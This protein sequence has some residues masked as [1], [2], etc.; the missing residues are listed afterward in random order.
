[1]IIG[2]KS[3]EQIPTDFLR[4]LYNRSLIYSLNCF[5]IG[6]GQSGK[7]TGVFYIANRLKQIKLG[8]PL[9]TAT[10]KEWDYKRFTSTDPKTFVTLWDE[11]ENEILALEEASDQLFYLD[12]R[13]VMSRV[14]SSTTSVQGMKHNICFIITPYFD[15]L[16]KNAR[17]KLDFV[18]I[19]H[20]RN[21]FRRSVV[22]TPKYVRLNWKSFKP[23]FKPIQNMNLTYSRRFLNEAK[24]YTNWLKKYK[25]DISDKNKRLVGIYNPLSPISDGNIPE[26]VDNILKVIVK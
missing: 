21:D 17:S 16:V 13:S 12:W 7:S 22:V 3:E 4:L 9:K 18:A 23:E 10:W 2:R 5:V 19:F 6:K 24:K 14:F 11:C 25:S 26:W 8:I 15:D 20:H 1:M